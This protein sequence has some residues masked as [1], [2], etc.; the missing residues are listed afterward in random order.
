MAE[1]NAVTILYL[2]RRDR[3]VLHRLLRL[4]HTIKAF[5]GRSDTS[6]IRAGVSRRVHATNEMN[7]EQVRTSLTESLKMY[8][9]SDPWM[10]ALL[11][12]CFCIV[13]ENQLLRDV[14]P[15]PD[16]S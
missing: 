1:L 7:A 3:M 10:K 4:T 15:W 14:P 2:F 8:P 5:D 12:I 11:T 16:A 6:K 9:S 13:L